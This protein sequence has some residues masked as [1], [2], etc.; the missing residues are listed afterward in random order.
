MQSRSDGNEPTYEACQ[1]ECPV[2][3]CGAEACA[4]ALSPS[5][6]VEPAYLSR[7]PQGGLASSSAPHALEHEAEGNPR[8]LPPVL[9]RA[10]PDGTDDAQRSIRDPRA[11]GVA[12]TKSC[13]WRRHSIARRLLMG[14]SSGFVSGSSRTRH[15]HRLLTRPNC[16]F[17]LLPHSRA[18]DPP[19]Q[20]RLE[21]C[22]TS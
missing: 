12:M 5:A 19:H 20:P 13:K 7:H 11:I 22:V 10:R 14:A 2:Q 1:V 17:L 3:G 8:D 21:P 16:S 6:S 4:H 9:C 15:I 18:A